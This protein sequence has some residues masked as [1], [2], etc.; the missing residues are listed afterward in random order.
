MTEQ[1]WAKTE[2]KL[3][4][5]WAIKK[6]KVGL[7]HIDQNENLNHS[8]NESKIRQKCNKTKHKSGQTK[9]PETFRWL[10]FKQE[11]IWTHLEVDLG[12]GNLAGDPVER[13]SAV[14]ILSMDLDVKDLWT[15]FFGDCFSSSLCALL[16]EFRFFV[17]QFSLDEL[18]RQSS[19]S[20]SSG[21]IESLLDK[22]LHK[23]EKQTQT[24]QF[25]NCPFQLSTVRDKHFRHLPLFGA[26]RA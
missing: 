25:T 20:F 2:Q 3:S 21:K 6:K 9:K 7:E 13:I 4:K 22:R 24:L 11:S 1:N 10:Y 8:R 17:W 19:A 26:E 5:N 23:I 15:D 14:L 12:K 16:N 18:L